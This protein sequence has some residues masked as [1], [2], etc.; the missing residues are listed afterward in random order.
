[1]KYTPV[2]KIAAFFILCGEELAADLLKN[3]PSNEVRKVVAAM[4]RM[5]RL[6]NED[7]KRI[8]AELQQQ[9]TTPQSALPSSETTMNLAHQLL[10]KHGVTANVHPTRITALDHVSPEEIWEILANEHPQAQALIVANLP[11]PLAASVLKCVPRMQTG[12]LIQRVAQL[13]PVELKVLAELNEQLSVQ[14]SQREKVR[15]QKIGGRAKA[16]KL[17]DGLADSEQKRLLL[18]VGEVDPELAED[19]ERRSYSFERLLK[20]EQQDLRKLIEQTE[21]S[22]WVLALR[23]VSGEQQ[24]QLLSNVSNRVAADTREALSIK[25]KTLKEDVQKAQRRLIQTALV[26]REKKVLSF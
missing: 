1:M 26:L 10:A 5:Q 12:S 17:L 8:V 18:A 25:G 23:I 16:A 11:K 14:V 9:L 4:G 22:D 13:Q 24:E 6:P 7:L 2:E 20:M 3:L 19:L 15:M 21:W